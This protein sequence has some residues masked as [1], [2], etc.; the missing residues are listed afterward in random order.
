MASHGSDGRCMTTSATALE[1]AASTPCVARY[2]SAVVGI[3]C[4][5]A[6]RAREALHGSEFGA[7]GARVSQPRVC[8][9]QKQSR[10]NEG[11]TNAA[12]AGTAHGAAHRRASNAGHAPSH[13]RGCRGGDHRT[14]PCCPCKVHRG[15]HQCCRLCRHQR[16]KRSN[17][18]CAGRGRDER[19]R[20]ETAGGH[21]HSP[22]AHEPRHY[23]SL[24]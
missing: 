11:A 12:G 15:R 1:M 6:L 24:P 10:F 2:S 18:G 8:R 7:A 21:R 19:R 3:P 22:H 13:N 20:E 5:S 23:Y 9:A 17:K 14:T 16:K 4:D